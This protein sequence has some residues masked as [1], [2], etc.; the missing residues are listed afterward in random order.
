MAKSK[1]KKKATKKAK[2][3]PSR[4]NTT[5]GKALKGIRAPKDLTD[6]VELADWLELKALSSRDGSSSKSDLAGLLRRAGGY[7]PAKDSD[8]V[9]Q[10]CLA[11]FSELDTRPK[12]T[13]DSYPFTIGA[14]VVRVK[15]K[16][17]KAYPAYVFCLCLSAWRWKSGNERPDNAR[18]LFEDLSCFAAKNYLGGEVLRFAHPREKALSEFPTA[19]DRLCELVGEGSGYRSDLPRNN[20]KDDTLDVVAW[21]SFPDGRGGKVVIFGQCASGAN[22]LSKRSELKPPAFVDQW[23]QPDFTVECVQAFFVPHRIRT[24]IW[25]ETTRKAGIPFDRCRVAYWSHQDGPI[26]KKDKLSAWAESAI[27]HQ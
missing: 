10:L 23:I 6:S 9:E 2:K 11:A 13:G 8:T 19:V 17:F 15:P 4:K 16:A 14:G 18:Q 5:K 7:D 21:K 22:W 27:P 3:N 12:A 20:K 1:A 24:E 25:N 26:P